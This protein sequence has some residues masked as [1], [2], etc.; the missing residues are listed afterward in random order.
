MDVSMLYA[1]MDMSGFGVD[2]DYIS[3]SEIQDY[4]DQGWEVEE[5][6]QD[7]FKGFI[8]SKKDISAKELEASMK[9]TQS[10]LSGETGSI[11]FTRQGLKYIFDW[12]VF[13]REQGEE[14]SGMMHLL[15]RLYRKKLGFL[16]D[17]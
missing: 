13:D 7:G 3:E 6:D 2:A 10:Q 12:Q 17:T 9:D 11:K 5:Y 15:F 16:L 1:M 8:L 14:L 4:R